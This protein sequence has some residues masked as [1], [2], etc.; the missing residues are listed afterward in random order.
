MLTMLL[1]ISIAY[2]FWH[3]EPITTQ[4]T[5]DLRDLAK[6]LVA[7]VPLEAHLHPLDLMFLQDM[8]AKNA[9]KVENFLRS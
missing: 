3:K 9:Q 2:S 6:Y 5:L 8:R 4:G 1:K 7:I